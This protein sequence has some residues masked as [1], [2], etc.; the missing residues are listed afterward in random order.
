M[1]ALLEESRS[2]KAT[3][4]KI[5]SE[6]RLVETLSRYGTAKIAGSYAL[7]VML[8]PDIDL[9]V[10]APTYEWKDMK[11]LMNELMDQRYF[12]EI[13]FLNWID[14]PAE[15]RVS[16]RGYY[17]QPCRWVNDVFW[18]LD[19]WLIT[20]EFDRGA[21]LTSKFAKLLAVHP[22]KRENILII[23]KAMCRDG[24]YEKGVDGQCIYKAV[25]ED[26]IETEEE[27]RKTLP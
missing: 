14:F 22:E 21:E 12:S 19:V 26:G 20:P 23:K 1:K 3:A 9:Y 6:S 27:F 2:I 25:L 5:L 24:K 15:D 17:F 13:A 8:R 7:D 4:D 11:A 18:K 10:I 16:I